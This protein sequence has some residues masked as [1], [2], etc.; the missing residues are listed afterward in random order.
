MKPETSGAAQNGEAI[1]LFKPANKG[2]K[3]NPARDC[4]AEQLETELE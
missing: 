4:Y 1:R 3:Q 2:E